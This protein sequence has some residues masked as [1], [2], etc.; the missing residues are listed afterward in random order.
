MANLSSRDPAPPKGAD[1]IIGEALQKALT[2]TASGGPVRRV[3]QDLVLPQLGASDRFGEESGAARSVSSSNLDDFCSLLSSNDVTGVIAYLDAAAARGVD[4]D[5]LLLGLLAGAAHRLGQE[6]ET[7]R[8]PFADVTVGMSRLQEALQH[9]AMNDP[10]RPVYAGG[11]GRALLAP[12][13]GEQHNFAIML[14]D[15]MFHRAGWDVCTLME[16]SRERLGDIAAS[17]PFD[18]VGLSAS[19]RDHV[20]E[21]EETIRTVRMKSKN[22]NIRVIVG[23]V[24]FTDDPGLMDR[25][26]A[27]AAP[28]DLRAAVSWA[29]KVIVERQPELTL[30]M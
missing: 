4:F 11:R 16:A 20:A 22:Q 6:W 17:S 18:I 24:I 29:E 25:V 23:G 28:S 9:V 2:Q 19:T 8:R 27:D 12:C 1:G 30:N 15:C 7:D 10:T 5:G 14:L 3:Y 26:N 13:P 21:L